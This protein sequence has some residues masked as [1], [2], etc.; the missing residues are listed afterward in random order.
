[1]PVYRITHETTYAHAAT[2]GAAWQMLQ[3]HPRAETAQECLDFQLRVAPALAELSERIDTFGNRRHFFTVREPH[4][5]LSIAC[6]SIVRREEP[7]WPLP[8]LTPPVA[9]ARGRTDALVNGAG[10]LL[11][12]YRHA[13]AHVPF[14][15]AAARLADG[16][17]EQTTPLLNWIEQLGRRFAE[18]F[19]F[20]AQA[21]DVSTPLAKVLE[22]K[23]GVCQDFTHLFLS[24]VRQRGL[25]AAYVSGYLLTNPPPGRPRL[26]G[27]DAMHAWAAVH[28]P[29][30]GWVDYDPTNSCFA[31]SGHIVVARG[32]DYADVSPTRGV[33]TGATPPP[34]R[35]AVTVE[36]DE[37][38]VGG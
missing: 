31:G 5:E 6:Q 9:E 17:D 30:F 24:C 3:L 22:R 23:R 11:E 4:R 36:P 16:L 14:L 13:T 28:V 37:E 26:R 18:T 21:T 33:F 19:T 27:A 38:S 10:Y 34:P 20:D 32:R 1:M 25:P 8:G 2:A 29:D 15:S 35:V 7:T 12:Q